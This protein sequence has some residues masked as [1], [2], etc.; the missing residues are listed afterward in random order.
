MGVSI[1]S[2][3]QLA[4][5]DPRGAEIVDA[6]RER[7]FLAGHIPGAVRMGWEA[8]CESA[9]ELAGPMLAQEGYWGALAAVGVPECSRRLASLG[10]R[11]DHPIVVYGDG[12]LTRG[13]EGRIAWMLLYFGTSH[14][15]LLDGGWSGWTHSGGAIQYETVDPPA[16]KFEVRLQ[17]ERRRT[18]DAL[19]ASLHEGRMPALIDT[20]SVAEFVGEVQEYLPRRGRLP[21]ARLLPFA[22]LFDGDGQYITRDRYLSKLPGEPCDTGGLVAYCEVGVRASLFAMLHEAYT[23]EIV[24]VF[25][26]SLVQWSLEKDLP[27]EAGPSTR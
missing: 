17:P 27:L 18:L 2:P 14:V 23:G 20:R 6:R 5:G 15:C 7:T 13:R 4:A 25:D 21:G 9:P 1:V 26:G 24:P 10:L 16:G 12:P 8:W 11:H 3:R 19:R 22:D